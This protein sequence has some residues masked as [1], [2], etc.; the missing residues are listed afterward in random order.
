MAFGF[1]IQLADELES[2][3]K[4]VNRRRAKC[5]K[6]VEN[7][8]CSLLLIAFDWP[9]PFHFRHTAQSSLKRADFDSTNKWAIVFVPNKEVKVLL[10]NDCVCPQCPSASIVIHLTPNVTQTLSMMFAATKFPP[11]CICI[12]LISPWF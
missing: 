12:W 4:K 2:G 10:R 3:A 1:G 7:F 5:A 8:Y 9:W 11:N 6:M